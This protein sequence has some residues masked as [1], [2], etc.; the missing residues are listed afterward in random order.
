[1]EKSLKSSGGLSDEDA[2]DVE[3]GLLLPWN[4]SSVIV[5]KF[6][7]VLLTNLKLDGVDADLQK[8]GET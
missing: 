5:V 7:N 3:D 6:V 1:M 8:E 4:S 2:S